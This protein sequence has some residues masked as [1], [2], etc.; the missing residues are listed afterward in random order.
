MPAAKSALQRGRARLKEL[1]KAQYDVRLPLLSETDRDRLLKYVDVFRSGDFDAV[2]LMLAD[3]VRLDL[4]AR[5]KLEG[6]ENVSRYFT[7]YAEATHWRFAAGVVD[8]QPVMLVFDSNGPMDAPAHFVVLD[9][10]AGRI[11]RIRDFLFAPYALEAS[12]W[13]RLS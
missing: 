3:D 5:L 1:A 6:R 4:V 8:G 2:R 12:A 9:W 13:L 11:I 10:R 7:G